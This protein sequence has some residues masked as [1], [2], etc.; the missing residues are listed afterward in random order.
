MITACLS[1]FLAAPGLSLARTTNGAALMRAG[2]FQDDGVIKGVRVYGS[3]RFS[4]H[5]VLRASGLRIGEDLT[6]VALRRS[7]QRLADTGAFTDIG[8]DDFPGMGGVVLHFNLRDMQ[9]LATCD[10]SR[11]PG[12]DQKRLLAELKAAVPLF[13]GR[14]PLANPRMLNTVRIHLA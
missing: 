11:I 2:G 9:P 7:Q 14:V 12:I 3:T 1:I 10:F 4:P 8:A 5:E 6:D 13:D